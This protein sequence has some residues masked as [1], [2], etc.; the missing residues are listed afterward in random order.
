MQRATSGYD[1]PDS[2][3]PVYQQHIQPP[4]SPVVDGRKRER[5]GS[6]WTSD[7]FSTR[8][9]YTQGFIYKSRRKKVLSE[10]ASARA[11]MQKQKVELVSREDEQDFDNKKQR[12]VTNVETEA[13]RDYLLAVRSA[14]ENEDL[15]QRIVLETDFMG[16][17]KNMHDQN[18]KTA[19]GGDLVVAALC[20]EVLGL[21]CHS[22][23]CGIREFLLQSNGTKLL[24][25]F[26]EDAVRRARG[27]S[28]RTL[29]L[30]CIA[31]S[32]LTSL[33]TLDRAPRLFAKA[34][35][36]RTLQSWK[37]RHRNNQHIS[38]CF[39]HVLF[40]IARSTPRSHPTYWL[41][42]LVTAV[43]SEFIANDGR[44]PETRHLCLQLTQIL[45]RI[46]EVKGVPGTVTK[47]KTKII[48]HVLS[49][50]E[51]AE[52]TWRLDQPEQWEQ[53][54]ESIC[55]I[56]YLITSST[57]AVAHLCDS[58]EER[59]ME[60]I[61]AMTRIGFEAA[62]S[63]LKYG[64]HDTC[65]AAIGNIART[66][67]FRP[68]LISGG[69]VSMIDRVMMSAV[70]LNESHHVAQCI[71]TLRTLASDDESNTE[72]V[73]LGGL[74]AL[75]K[76]FKYVNTASKKLHGNLNPGLFRVEILTASCICGM[77][78]CS[79]IGELVK[80]IGKDVSRIL[81]EMLRQRDML[82][83]R[84]PQLLGPFVTMIRNMSCTPIGLNI[85]GKLRG[86]SKTLTGMSKLIPMPRRT[87]SSPTEQ[88][89]ASSLIRPRERWHPV[90]GPD[91]KG[92]LGGPKDDYMIV[93]ANGNK[94]KHPE[95]LE[96][97]RERMQIS[98]A[99][100]LFNMSTLK[101]CC[102]HQIAKP[103]MIRYFRNI[104][105]GDN[106]DGTFDPRFKPP[107]VHRVQELTVATLLEIS[108]IFKTAGQ[109]FSNLGI[110]DLLVRLSTEKFNKYNNNTAAAGSNF[111]NTKDT[112]SEMEEKYRAALNTSVLAVSTMC[113]LTALDCNAEVLIRHKVPQALLLAGS[114]ASSP[115]PIRLRCAIAINNLVYHHPYIFTTEI[116]ILKKDRRMIRRGAVGLPGLTS[117]NVQI[118]KMPGAY[119]LPLAK[120]KSKSK[121]ASNTQNGISS[122]TKSVNASMFLSMLGDVDATVR[123]YA[124]SAMCHL[125]MREATSHKW[126]VRSGGV[127]QLLLTGVV[128]ASRDEQQTR[129]RGILGFIRL[130][131]EAGRKWLRRRPFST[132]R[133]VWAATSMVRDGDYHKTHPL[134]KF[135][136]SGEF[137]EL[138][139]ILLLYLS[140]TP[141]GR[142]LVGN[143]STIAIVIDTALKCISRTDAR[144]QNAQTL[145][146]LCI[147]A[148]VNLCCGIGSGVLQSPRDE[149]GQ[150][151]RLDDTGSATAYDSEVHRRRGI[152]SAI[153][154]GGLLEKIAV[155]AEQCGLEDLKIE[156][157]SVLSALVLSEDVPFDLIEE[158]GV[159]P[160]LLE[161]VHINPKSPN[162][163]VDL[164]Y[165]T[166]L[167]EHATIVAFHISL[168][169][170]LT[171]EYMIRMAINGCIEI[172]L[173]PVHAYTFTNRIKDLSLRT[174]ETFCREPQL[175][176]LVLS[177]GLLP[178]VQDL[179]GQHQ[180]P[181][182][183]HRRSMVIS[184]IIR[185]I[186]R[187]FPRYVTFKMPKQTVEDPAN[188]G[189]SALFGSGGDAG[190]NDKEDGDDEE[191]EDQDNNGGTTSKSYQAGLVDKNDEAQHDDKNRTVW[192]IL[193][194]KGIVGVLTQ[195]AS[196]PGDK[197]GYIHADCGRTLR[198]I[199]EDADALV[200]LA[201]LPSARE[202]IMELADIFID[203]ELENGARSGNKTSSFSFINVTGVDHVSWA[204]SN[205][206]CVP[207]SRRA[208]IEGDLLLTLEALCISTAATETSIDAASKAVLALLVDKIE[209]T[210]DKSTEIAD[211][212]NNVHTESHADSN[213]HEA[214]THTESN[215]HSHVGANTIRYELSTICCNEILEAEAHR[216]I[217]GMFEEVRRQRIFLPGARRLGLALLM[218]VEFCQKEQLSA[219]VDDPHEEAERKEMLTRAEVYM[220]KATEGDQEKLKG[221]SEEYSNELMAQM[222][223]P[224]VL[225]AEDDDTNGSPDLGP[226]V[227]QLD[228]GTGGAFV[229]KFTRVVPWPK[230][231]FTTY[232]DVPK[233]MRLQQKPQVVEPWTEPDLDTAKD[234]K[235]P[236]LT[237]FNGVVLSE[238]LNRVH[239]LFGAP[240]SLDL[241]RI[242]NV[243]RRTNEDETKRQLAEAEVE[244]VKL[245]QLERLAATE[246]NLLR[247]RTVDEK[248]NEKHSNQCAYKK[249]VQLAAN[250]TMLVA[251]QASA[252]AV[253][254]LRRKQHFMLAH[255]KS[256]VRLK[257]LEETAVFVRENSAR[258]FVAHMRARG[259]K[260]LSKRRKRILGTMGKLL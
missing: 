105:E 206:V 37:Q 246:K 178:F 40:N 202:K 154:A 244:L 31:A 157:G 237:G 177:H 54:V 179:I 185:L 88:Q 242:Q 240:L 14:I 256:A 35:A 26:S 43:S 127:H 125:V 250:N 21:V 27:Y 226:L 13:Q 91:A 198:N 187:R 25:E 153:A 255:T 205:L 165:W 186:T 196:A 109:Q 22:S 258:S 1:Q 65:L 64:L 97:E 58:R 133:V 219:P 11:R 235:L 247:W 8:Q 28:T 254:R 225:L 139:M 161:L 119:S 126:L 156:L 191:N 121:N 57:K 117:Q 232:P 128:R 20:S 231:A 172:V 78:S 192:H 197:L 86:L 18:R 253:E 122:R 230:T 195:L 239:P 151:R 222:C 112:T 224:T 136:D 34:N 146:R 38:Q 46:L 77:M 82:L 52:H 143:K 167:Q 73:K 170:R 59:L 39:V 229:A 10:S 149:R 207:D 131:A 93:D 19:D 108:R 184:R 115:Q 107:P 135:D 90:W 5:R 49:L 234:D 45:V 101:R 213:T 142:V 53:L 228:N 36:L 189:L 47:G 3:S 120:S 71:V 233:G 68:L 94:V 171:R 124:T 32:A 166:A 212:D 102:T 174:L 4:L 15:H 80:V 62:S 183:L 83:K 241:Q 252:V 17:L 152:F 23:V 111:G 33:S 221:L 70:S 210:N 160:C 203:G 118:L 67:R 74:S 60:L 89:I 236:P 147:A 72:V 208:F 84:H 132:P 75:L 55:A 145:L 87:I 130:C 30:T 41:E 129:R 141:H 138:G 227:S 193:A 95:I 214:D 217:R 257:K 16:T 163:V 181:V 85:Y 220:L 190:D 200:A 12:M 24:L 259:E 92:K 199:T 48:Y 162:S 249:Q 42:A 99:A 69:A 215:T 44:N 6:A 164:S 7:L 66:E 223:S 209:L 61:T 9:D 50:I 116:I 134:Q 56:V 248:Q 194:T 245:A 155:L 176:P 260:E 150:L 113:A 98:I 218:L 243:A 106:G 251:T 211:N 180:G 238:A 103:H 63:M 173:L 182:V 137:R 79:D 114:R 96:R 140:A 201:K 110:I 158:A 104:M 216:T 148:L 169:S 175:R 100:T 2:I 29:Q 188:V 81:N 204:L 51:H 76:A 123:R 144:P 159:I 168:L